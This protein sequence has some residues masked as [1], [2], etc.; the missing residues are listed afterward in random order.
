MR[1]LGPLAPWR[2]LR[3]LDEVRE[4]PALRTQ[5]K[6]GLKETKTL[7]KQ[8]LEAQRGLDQR[9]DLAVLL[10]RVEQFQAV[11]KQ[12]QLGPE[13]AVRDAL[14]ARLP[15]DHPQRLV[16]KDTSFKY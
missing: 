13:R 6:Q 8:M 2:L 15:A 5:V 10:T 14:T 16:Q 7:K 4:L 9:N 12:V 3:T 1:R 11:Y